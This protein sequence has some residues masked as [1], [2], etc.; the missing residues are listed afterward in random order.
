M[1]VGTESEHFSYKFIY[2]IDK[3]GL[4]KKSVL[5]SGLFLSKKNHFTRNSR[6]WLFFTLTF[7]YQNFE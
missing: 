5:I 2:H 4:F 3:Y 6:E 1:E 7:C